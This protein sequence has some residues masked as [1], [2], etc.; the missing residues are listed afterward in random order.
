MPKNPRGKNIPITITHRGNRLDGNDPTLAFELS[1]DRMI[2]NNGLDQVYSVKISNII[3]TEKDTY[4]YEVKTIDPYNLK[5]IPIK[6]PEIIY[7]DTKDFFEIKSV[8][9]ADNYEILTRKAIRTNWFEGAEKENTKLFDYCFSLEKILVRNSLEN[10]KN[11]CQ[12]NTPKIEKY[13][14]DPI[15]KIL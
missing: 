13:P 8:S 7:D 5:T 2:Q 4:S 11:I 12:K 10:R 1:N 14:G 3:R 9:A 15:S 6:G